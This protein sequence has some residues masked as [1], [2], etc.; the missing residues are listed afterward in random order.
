MQADSGDFPTPR[1]KPISRPTIPNA[2][3]AISAWYS[4][5]N[6]S[7]L[8]PLW[9]GFISIQFRWMLQHATQPVCFCVAGFHH[10]SSNRLLRV[11]YQKLDFAV[12]L[13]EP[14]FF[15]PSAVISRCASIRLSGRLGCLQSLPVSNPEKPRGGPSH[16]GQQAG[17]SHQPTSDMG[18]SPRVF[19]WSPSSPPL[20]NYK[21]LR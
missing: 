2:T 16:L 8:A 3:T 21:N 6:S 10:P 14:D 11:N 1:N 12:C 5:S 13:R 17:S 19:T 4:S 15:H 18:H 7:P 20:P 9:T